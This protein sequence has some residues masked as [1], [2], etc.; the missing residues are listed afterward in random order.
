MLTLTSNRE[1]W[2]HLVR[3]NNV[4]KSTGSVF[5]HCV[6]LLENDE[7]CARLRI[8]ERD[9]AVRSAFYFDLKG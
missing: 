5:V 6:D 4:N 8:L 9:E 2:M 3:F 1:V 7:V